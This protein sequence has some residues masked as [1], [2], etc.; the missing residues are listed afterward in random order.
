MLKAQILQLGLIAFCLSI[1]PG[2]KFTSQCVSQDVL[3]GLSDYLLRLFEKFTIFV[4]LGLFQLSWIKRVHS[5][6]ISN[7]MAQ[8]SYQL[9]NITTSSKIH[10]QKLSHEYA[11]PIKNCSSKVTQKICFVNSFVF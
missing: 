4:L 2:L 9:H 10:L 11:K 6:K 8:T 5:Y 7:P 1:P 3:D